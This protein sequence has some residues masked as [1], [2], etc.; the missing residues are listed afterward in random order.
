MSLH[1]CLDGHVA[2]SKFPAGAAYGG[3]MP[4]AYFEPENLNALIEVF[5]E[6]KRR[7]NSQDINDPTRLD[8]VAR[9]ILN[10]AADG[11]SPEMILQEISPQLEAS[12]KSPEWNSEIRAR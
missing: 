3:D 2:G 10:L 4:K 7:L 11:L 5:T 9:R 6:V 8:L 1:R 12:P